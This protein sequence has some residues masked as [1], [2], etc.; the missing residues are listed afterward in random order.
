MRKTPEEVAIPEDWPP[1]GSLESALAWA[2]RIGE[3]RDRARARWCRLR[4]RHLERE[5][6][7]LHEQID[8]LN[9]KVQ[10]GRLT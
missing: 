10:A 4:A 5:I 6:R 3:D 1:D 7:A 2:D 8:E 9:E